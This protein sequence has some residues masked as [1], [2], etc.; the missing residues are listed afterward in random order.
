MP[1]SASGIFFWEQM[2]PHY[3]M[4]PLPTLAFISQA[5][6][7]KGRVMGTPHRSGAVSFVLRTWAGKDCRMRSTEKSHI[8]C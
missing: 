3:I 7:E 2:E 8:C 4:A 1:Y 6:P 5:L